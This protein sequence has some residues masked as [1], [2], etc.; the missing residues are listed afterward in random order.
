MLFFGN[1]FDAS[2]SGGAIPEMRYPPT[3]AGYESETQ[4]GHVYRFSSCL[5]RNKIRKWDSLP[6][7]GAMV[8]NAS[9]TTAHYYIVPIPFIAS[10]PTSDTKTEDS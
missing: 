4:T 8:N 9:I 3:S 5:I 10:C 2:V 7:C 6:G 1:V